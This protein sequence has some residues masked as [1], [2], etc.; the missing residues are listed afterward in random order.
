MFYILVWQHPFVNVFKHFEIQSWKK[1]TKE[2]EV[3]SLMVCY[4]MV[5][6]CVYLGIHIKVA[7]HISLMFLI[8]LNVYI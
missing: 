8:T 6:V 3:T 2:G 1:A 5:F 7:M 4:V